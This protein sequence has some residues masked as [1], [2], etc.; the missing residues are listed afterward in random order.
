MVYYLFFGVVFLNIYALLLIYLRPKL[1]GVKLYKPMVL[2]VKLSVAPSVALILTVGLLFTLARKG[3]ETNNRTLVFVAAAICALGFL[4]W[5]L[6]LPNAG[7][8]ITELNFNHRE[9]DKDKVP[10]WYDI[11]AVL[12]LALSG[13]LNTLVNVMLVQIIFTALFYPFDEAPMNN[14]QSWVLI[15]ILLLLVS[16]GMYLGRYIRFNSWDIIKPLRFFKILKT[17]CQEQG[18]V[19]N[20]VC[21]VLFHTLFFVCLYFTTTGAMLNQVIYFLWN[22]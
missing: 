20:C 3:Y 7:Y 19:K 16:V 21:F 6:L 14:P 8:L 17:H 18:V 5:L 1:Y 12:S 2:N 11:V 13:V 22:F 15:V 9:Q 10:L 4:V